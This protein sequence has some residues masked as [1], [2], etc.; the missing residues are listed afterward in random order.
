MHVSRLL[1]LIGIFL[2][3]AISAHAEKP[4]SPQSAVPD[5]AERS[6]QGVV[7]IS[8][9]KK[10]DDRFSRDPLWRWFQGHGRRRSPSPNSLGSGVVVSKNGLILTNHH[11]IAGADKISVNFADGQELSA[12]L[13]GEDPKS[14]IAV[15]RLKSP[16]SDLKPI[17]MGDSK[18][19][20]LGETVLAI[21]NPFGLGHTV[22]MG[23]VS[24]K[25]RA[26]LD[27][28]DYENF[29]QTDAAINPGNSGGALVNTRG[30]LVGI[31]TAIYSRS[32][33]YQGI[34]FAIPSEMA[35][36]IMRSLIDKGRV[37]RGYLGVGIQAVDSKLAKRFK[38]TEGKSGVLINYVGPG[39]P[40][41]KAGLKAGDVILSLDGDV[42]SGPDT[43][44]NVVAMKGAG[45]SISLEIWRNNR[46]KSVKTK[47]GLLPEVQ[48]A[49]QREPAPKRKDRLSRMGLSV[50]VI[51]EN[52]RRQFNLDADEA[53][54][55]VSAVMP[56]TRA[57]RAGLRPG[58]VIMR[59]NRRK[60]KDVASFESA[61]AQDGEDVLL[62]IRRGQARLFVV[63]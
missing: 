16:P 51:D 22:T 18:T 57:H 41:K 39:T 9:T 38:L 62:R 15:I 47:L 1:S 63:L 11:V 46:T 8:T 32:G 21:G 29:I 42:M 52:V 60:I 28:T 5:I 4:I 48:R 36:K 7:N 13:V 24:A 20:R 54:V 30:E 44:R 2:L 14:D 19:L 27:I 53:G 43:L 6:V 31:N 61:I 58:D 23:I 45:T 35:S 59:A 40:A 12:T 17:P 37:D 50:T 3:S 49:S 33:G 55:V 10:M 34:G 56:M 25:G 26:N